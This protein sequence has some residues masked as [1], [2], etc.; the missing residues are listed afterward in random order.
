MLKLKRLHC[1]AIKMHLDSATRAKT[2][3]SMQNLGQNINISQN[4][5]PDSAT[6]KGNLC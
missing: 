5:A 1:G 3:E 6:L 2:T 4:L